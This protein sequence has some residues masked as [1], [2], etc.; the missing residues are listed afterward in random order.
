MVTN[1]TSFGRSGLSDWIV[2]RFTAVYLIFYFLF[3]M[4]YLLTAG[5]LNYGQWKALFDGL[6]MRIG[7]LLAILS[8]CAHAWVGMWTV[9]TDYIKATGL[10]LLVELGV[11]IVLFIYAVWGVHILWGL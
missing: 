4:F 5:E 3:I 9:A 8:L 7:T 1:V 11:G 6:A 2:Q 10:R